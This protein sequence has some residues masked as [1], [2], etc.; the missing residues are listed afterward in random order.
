MLEYKPISIC[1]A[2]YKLISKVLA[3][4]LKR[5]LPQ[6]ISKNQRARA[7]MYSSMG[8]IIQGIQV[9]LRSFVICVSIN[10][11]YHSRS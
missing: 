1:N 7:E 6:L 9:L 11:L 4:G 2:R 3:N 10:M 5:I 8:V